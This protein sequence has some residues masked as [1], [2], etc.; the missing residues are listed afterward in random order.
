MKHQKL[1]DRITEIAEADGWSVSIEEKKDREDTLEFTFGKFTDADQ[2]FSFYV[3]M[4]DGDIYTLIEDIN[5]YYEGYDP[6]EEALLWLGPDGHG[7]NGAPYRMTDV[8]KDMEQC[9]TFIGELLELLMKPTGMSAC[10]PSKMKK[11]KKITNK[12]QDHDNRRKF[13]STGSIKE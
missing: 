11:M 13:C 2:D 9:E 4:T 6:D 7:M 3:E 10:M 5:R 8:V 1:I 12:S